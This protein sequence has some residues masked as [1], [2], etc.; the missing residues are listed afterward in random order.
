VAEIGEQAHKAIPSLHILIKKFGRNLT[1]IE[2]LA[3]RENNYSGIGELALSTSYEIE[4]IITV[5]QKS[6]LE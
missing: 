4:E 2:N 6:K 5:A 1:K 3:L